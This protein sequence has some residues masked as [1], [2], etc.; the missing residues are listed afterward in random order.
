MYI[1]IQKHGRGA[2]CAHQPPDVH[3][4]RGDLRADHHDH[5]P[6]AHPPEAC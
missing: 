6:E 5:E 4:E 2:C 3:E 1:D